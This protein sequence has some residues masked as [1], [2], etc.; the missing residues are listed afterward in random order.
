MKSTLLA[1]L[2]VLIGCTAPYPAEAEHH[3]GHA[4]GFLTNSI[5]Q[6]ELAQDHMTAYA[7]SG[8]VFTSSEQRSIDVFFTYTSRALTSIDNAIAL[9]EDVDNGDLDEVRRIL[10]EPGMGPE[11]PI[12]SVSVRFSGGLARV[13][14]LL[15]THPEA[16]N[17]LRKTIQRLTLAWA[18]V[19]RA[20]WHTNDAIRE[21]VYND[22]LFQ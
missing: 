3:R 15:T 7:N 16:D 21:E 11:N 20:I 14:M 8:E 1:A 18:Q 19:D 22:P 17:E 5:V 4:V 2:I 9:L 6:F 10:N 12:V 13:R